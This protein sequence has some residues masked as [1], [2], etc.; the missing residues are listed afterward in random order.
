MG[1][2]DA[3]NA[4]LWSAPWAIGES[5]LSGLGLGLGMG[6]TSKVMGLR[7]AP[8]GE[9][10]HGSGWRLEIGTEVEGF[11]IGGR[12]CH[13]GRPLSVVIDIRERWECPVVLSV[14]VHLFHDLY[15][16]FFTS[17][18]LPSTQLP[19]LLSHF[20][21]S[22]P[23]TRQQ[24]TI[25]LVQWPAIRGGL[26]SNS[27]QFYIVPGTFE[28]WSPIV[29]SLNE[30]P[31]RIKQVTLRRSLPGSQCLLFLLELEVHLS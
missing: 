20:T 13:S 15:L 3:S 19:H 18:S 24:N 31:H 16:S 8:V 21:R 23:T 28:D 14:I 29:L 25:I 6:G 10:G 11:T 2:C 9:G 12:Q 17:F 1:S 27:S 5:R 4:L 7:V 30:I 26:Q 22:R